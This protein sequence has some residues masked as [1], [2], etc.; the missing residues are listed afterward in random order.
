MSRTPLNDMIRALA[1]RDLDTVDAL[2]VEIGQLGV[3]DGL[4]LVGAA[5]AVA[6]HRHFGPDA[7]PTDVSAFVA[8]ARDLY[9]DDESLP[10]LEMEGLI[11]A[12]LGEYDLVDNIPAETALGAELFILGHLLITTPLTPTELDEFMAEAEELA[13]EHR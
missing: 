10:R 5:F 3:A 2:A 11:R 4:R 1:R 12:A 7:T 13:E 8:G 6:V 9:P